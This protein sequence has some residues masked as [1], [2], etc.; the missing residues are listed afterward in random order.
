MCKQLYIRHGYI[1]ISSASEYKQIERDLKLVEE[2]GVAYHVCH[3][4][5]KESVDL[6]RNAK[7][8]G[9]N[10]TCE[11]A[12]HYLTLTENDL[13]DEGRFKMNPPV[14]SLEDRA[15]LIEGI[16]DGTIDVI[17]TDHAPHSLEEKAKGL[18]GS[19]FGIVGLET[20]FP[21]LYTELVL[22]GI[23]TLEKLVELLTINP[24]NRFSLPIKKDDYT[25]F[26]IKN[27]YKIDRKDFL[28]MGKASPFDG[29]EVYGK[30]ILTVYNGKEVYKRHKLEE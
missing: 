28:S 18:K 20:A 4:S 27:K 12:P 2:L 10:V 22:K 3:I 19:P 16:K 5:T 26:E 7:L 29:K 24:R 8:R 30:C 23:I 1:G 17:A 13:K 6:I 15:A 9:V 14:R 25:V 11:T 21:I